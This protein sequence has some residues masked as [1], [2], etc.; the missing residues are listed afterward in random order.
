VTGRLV[1][2]ATPLGNLA[3]LS[4]RAIS[5]LG[6]VDAI[7]CEDTRMTRKLLDL[8]G[9]A[10]PPLF[11]VHEHNEAAMVAPVLGRLERGETVALVTDAGLPAISDP[12]QRIVRA[13]ADAGFDVSVVPGPSAFVAAVAISGLPAERLVFEGFLPRKGAERGRRLSA[14]AAEPRTVA[15]YEAPHR[16]RATLGDLESA[17]GGSRRVVLVRELTKLHEEVWRGTLAGAVALEAAPRGEYVIVLEGAPPPPP[18]GD[19]VI[20][21]L[22]EG[23]LARGSDRREAIASVAGALG[24]PKRRVY[25]AAVRLRR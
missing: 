14:I 1:L 3:D 21:S 2:V 16:L 19:A 25:D 4:P 6:S 8:V 22:L 12:G 11:S 7:A 10:A 23:E 20:E 18:V 24:V 13:A 17:C 9:V 15:L 5:V